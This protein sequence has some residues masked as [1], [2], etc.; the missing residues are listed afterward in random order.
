M[1]LNLCEDKDVINFVI[2]IVFVVNC[3]V[4]ELFF[5]RLGFQDWD[6]EQFFFINLS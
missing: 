6:Y 5:L 3:K 2:F 4:Q 1:I